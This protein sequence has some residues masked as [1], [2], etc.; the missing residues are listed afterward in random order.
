MDRGYA[1]SHQEDV[2]RMPFMPKVRTRHPYLR[3]IPHRID[4]FSKDRHLWRIVFL[5]KKIIKGANKDG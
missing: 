3:G 1:F 5:M 4:R 2:L